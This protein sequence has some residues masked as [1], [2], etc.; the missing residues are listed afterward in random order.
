MALFGEKG[1]EAIMPLAKTSKGLGVV[2]AI[3]QNG[4]GAK[5]V[6]VHLENVNINAVDAESFYNLTARNPEAI[7]EPIKM[8][9]VA[10][11]QDLRELL[12]E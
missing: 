7:I 11:D 3:P 9:L 12:R 8:T 10:G 5:E 1:P 4:G 2:A 6:H